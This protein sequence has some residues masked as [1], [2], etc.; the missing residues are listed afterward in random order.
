MSLV[1][2]L[3]L[4]AIPLVTFGC[5]KVPLDP[6]ITNNSQRDF[7]FEGRWKCIRMESN[8]QMEELDDCIA[9]I[10]CTDDK[11]EYH[12]IDVNKRILEDDD[13]RYVFRVHEIAAGENKVLVEF[14]VI[15]A[16]EITMRR[17]LIV[18]R[19]D[20]LIFVWSLDYEK[21][22]DILYD[23]EVPA[24][25]KMSTFHSTLKCKPERVLP[26]IRERWSELISPTRDTLK[27]LDS[28]L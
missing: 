15:Q 2:I 12:F 5:G 20:D 17:P 1:R 16:N 28:A 25:L 22:A 8:P 11:S 21:L 13:V 19:K 18:E 6:L 24:L 10:N 23:N 9:E 7:G 27:R 3:I 14:E 26:I 4:V